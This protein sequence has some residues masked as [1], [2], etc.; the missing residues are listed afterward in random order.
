MSDQE[1]DPTSL[2]KAKA[3]GDRIRFDRNE[4]DER[5][6]RD[7]KALLSPEDQA[8]IGDLPEEPAARPG[9]SFPIDLETLGIIGED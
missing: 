9:L 1:F 6:M 5:V 7:L 3:D 8:R 4:L 2:Q